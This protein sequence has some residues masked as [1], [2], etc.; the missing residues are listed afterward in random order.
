MLKKRLLSPFFSSIL[1][2]SLLVIAGC[3]KK[4]EAKKIGQSSDHQ[5]APPMTSDVEALLEKQELVCEQGSFCPNYIAKVAIVHG[6]KVNFCTGFLADRNIV[7][8]AT[9]CLTDILRLNNQDCSRDVFFFFPNHY[10][11]SSFRVGCKKVL[12][13]SQLDSSNPILWRDDVSFLELDEPVRFRRSLYFSR[14]GIENHKSYTMW[15]IEQVDKHTAFIRRT[16]CEAIHKS[17]VNPL[18][19]KASSPNMMFAGCTLKRGNAG[20]P[21]VDSRGKVRAMAS[22]QMDSKLRDYINS[23]DLLSEPLKEMFHATNF[24]CAPLL[25]DT[26]VMDE[27]ECTKELNYAALDNSRTDMLSIS[28]SFNNMRLMLEERL[29][30]LNQYFNIG[31]NLKAQ[32]DTQRVELFPKCF[33]DVSSW[34]ST[35]NLS[36]NAF[37]FSVDFPQISFQKVMDQYGRISGKEVEQGEKR[38]FIQFS[39]KSVNRYRNSRVFLWNEDINLTFNNITDT[40][41]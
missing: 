10:N 29:S 36:R 21:L 26:D 35:L 30:G 5:T 23:T 3:G 32:G 24:A 22:R 39:P 2:V 16:E 13:V 28:D 14:E 41:F 4:T 17:Y 11:R 27:R 20:A 40:C 37:S 9:S 34:L 6:S 8:T 31:V 12:Q 18:A 33:K 1:G 38:H 7:A 25:F 15:G 19:S